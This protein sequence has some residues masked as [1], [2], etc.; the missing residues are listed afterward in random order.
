MP[1]VGL[2]GKN[3]QEVEQ[4]FLRMSGGNINCY[5]ITGDE[6]GPELDV[7]VVS[8]VSPALPEA[9]PRLTQS[10]YLVVN[11]DDKAILPNIA[12]TNVKL[13]TY[14]FSNKACITASSI[15]DDNMHICIQRGFVALDGAVKDPQEFSA[16]AGT[17]PPEATLGAAA[18]WAICG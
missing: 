6:H 12:P 14:G 3:G 5:H 4:E 15:T 10:G 9:I 1:S 2:I 18:A 17:V 11:A 8:G 13:I 7:L 16:T